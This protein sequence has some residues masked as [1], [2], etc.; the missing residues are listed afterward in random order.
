[1][2]KIVLDVETVETKFKFDGA[3]HV[4]YGVEE[5]VIEEVNKAIKPQKH[6][7][8]KIV[9]LMGV[10][11]PNNPKKK[12][13]GKTEI[14]ISLE[15]TGYCCATVEFYIQSCGG[16]LNHDWAK[17]YSALKNDELEN[18]KKISEAVMRD[19]PNSLTDEEEEALR[20]EVD[21]LIS[22]SKLIKKV[23]DLEK[24]KNLK[25]TDPKTNKVLV[26]APAFSTLKEIIVNSN[27]DY[28]Q[29]IYS[30]VVINFGSRDS[31]VE[32]T[33]NQGRSHRLIISNNLKNNNESAMLFA[34]KLK[35]QEFEIHFPRIDKKFIGLASLKVVRPEKIVYPIS[36]VE[37][38]EVFKAYLERSS[39]A[40]PSLG[41]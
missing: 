11:E 5:L 22:R 24:F 13:K 1:M 39:N 9:A 15:K 3:S 17:E 35:A 2:S 16:I 36:N 38:L 28:V 10:P 37:A 12:Q 30:A 4:K 29:E 34:M 19:D 40:Q 27:F 41:F 7:F 25:I 33:D 8:K 20:V 26:S 32:L 14:L 18:I 23:E 6:I 31:E 21:G